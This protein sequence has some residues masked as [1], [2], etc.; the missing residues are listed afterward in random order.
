MVAEGQ[1]RQDLYYR[2]SVFP[3]LLPPLRKRREDTMPLATHFAE[4]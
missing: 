1:F 4:K 3:V 2:L